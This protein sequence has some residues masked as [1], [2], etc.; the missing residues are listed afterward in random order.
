MY[1]HIYLEQF[2][3]DS[4]TE[5]VSCGYFIN[6]KDL[7]DHLGLGMSQLNNYSRNKKPSKPLNKCSLKRG[8]FSKDQILLDIID[9]KYP[10]KP[11]LSRHQHHGR[12]HCSSV[13]DSSRLPPQQEQ[14]H[15]TLLS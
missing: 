12:G 15:Q 9:S 7:A 1:Y 2:S 14:A 6:S 11:H 4:K 8:K 3:D 5:L 13:V 10:L